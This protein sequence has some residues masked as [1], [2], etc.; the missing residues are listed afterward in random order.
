MERIK[1]SENLTIIHFCANFIHMKKIL[2]IQSFSTFLSLA[3]LAL[4]LLGFFLLI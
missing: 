3:L 1:N 2:A 4:V